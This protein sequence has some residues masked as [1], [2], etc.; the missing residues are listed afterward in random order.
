M[1]WEW[2][3]NK[4]NTSPAYLPCSSRI[5]VVVVERCKCSIN[6]IRVSTSLDVRESIKMYLIPRQAPTAVWVDAR[7]EIIAIDDNSPL[8][9]T[10]TLITC[11]IEINTSSSSSSTTS[12]QVKGEYLPLTKINYQ[13][14]LSHYLSQNCAQFYLIHAVNL[15]RESHRW[16][17]QRTRFVHAIEAIAEHRILTK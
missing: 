7:F 13:L 16:D 2:K 14:I 1:E 17:M 12:L 9:F 5:F 3:K 4:K 10:H 6:S 11:K 8:K 15:C